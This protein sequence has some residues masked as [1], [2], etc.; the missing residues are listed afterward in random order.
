MDSMEAPNYADMDD[1]EN[2][3]QY[4]EEVAIIDDQ[5]EIADGM[6]MVFVCSRSMFVT[7]IVLERNSVYFKGFE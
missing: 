2:P 3:D 7:R 1:M 4:T 6:P 5:I